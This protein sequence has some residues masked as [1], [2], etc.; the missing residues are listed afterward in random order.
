MLLKSTV[1]AMLFL[2]TSSVAI[3]DSLNAEMDGV[4]PKLLYVQDHVGQRD[5]DGILSPGERRNPNIDYD[6]AQRQGEN[7]E[8]GRYD[9]PYNESA[10]D[11]DRDNKRDDRGRYNWRNSK[12]D[13]KDDARE[14]HDHENHDRE[15]RHSWWP[16]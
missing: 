15:D 13:R 14:D 5:T 2:G 6:K 16:W 9:N 7:R 12:H 4:A 8:D 11:T 3:A 1:L 10:A